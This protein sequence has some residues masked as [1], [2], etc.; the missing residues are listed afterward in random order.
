MGIM[1]MDK[2][3]SSTLLCNQLHV[4]IFSYSAGLPT[5][6]QQVNVWQVGEGCVLRT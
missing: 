5:F 3:R 4:Y 2:N 1:N 6:I